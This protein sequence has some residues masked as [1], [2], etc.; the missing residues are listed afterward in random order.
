[1]KRLLILFFSILFINGF[2]QDTLKGYTLHK[3]TIKLKEVE[4][5]AF[6]PYQANFL[7]PISFKNLS[8]VDI[9]IKNYGQEPS[10]ILNTT[11]AIT[12]FS[13]AG[14]PWGYSYIRLRGIDQTR[15]NMTLNGVP[16]N[17][18]E[19]QGCYF[20][21]FPDFLQSLDMLQIQRG[22]GTTKNGVSS[23]G[24]SL[25]F[26]SYQPK[27]TS[28]SATIGGGSFGALKIG[29]QIDQK[30]K[31]GG[32]YIQMTDVASD[33]YKYHSS[34]HSQ[35]FF[36]NSYYDIGKNTF[37]IIGFAGRQENQLA[38]L[39][40]PIDSINKDRRINGASDKEH[41]Q[42]EQ[43]HIQFH[44]IYNIS[45]TSKLNYCVYY[46]HLNGF[47]TF[48]LYNFL[49]IPE[50]G[51]IYRYDLKSNFVGAYV[52]Y[53]QR[54]KRWN[55]YIGINGY[56]YNRNHIGSSDVDGY[57]YTNTGYRNE[58]SAYFKA[59][60]NVWKGLNLFADV[61]YRHTDFRYAG[62]VPLK[63]F[64]WDFI[65]YDLGIDYHLNDIVFYYSFGKTSREP[66]RN[67]IFYGN[68]NLQADSTG[69]PIYNDLKPETS[70]DHE[71]G[72]R[73]LDNDFS[74]DFN[75]FYMSFQNEITLN[76]QY[77]P[78]GLPLHDN[79]TKSYRKGFE[80]DI[81]YKWD[82]NKFNVIGVGVNGSYNDCVI[83]QVGTSSKPVLSPLWLANCDVYYKYKWFTVGLNYRY[84]DYSFVDFA[85]NNKINEFSTLNGK[86]GIVWQWVDFN[87]FVNNITNTNYFN[88]GQM[89]YDG[90]KP[91][92]FVGAPI[93]FFASLKMTLNY[94]KNNK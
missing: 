42:F 29:F 69:N 78:T 47:Y 89:N 58:A 87:I 48:D 49:E 82:L 25:N 13:D 59:R 64:S 65:N 1:M 41:D 24:G 8:K 43:Y 44:H 74:V 20:S 36:F 16:L 2:S 80:T 88:G 62:N 11:P 50:V 9:G 7:T 67:D 51:S 38:W 66:S 53:T 32:V 76:G 60:Y 18:P 71:L 54:V 45:N 23:F 35:S 34:N 46:N 92:Y 22:S 14:S 40:V 72:F 19:D 83:Q 10:Q 15:I 6:S 93:N 12:S 86:I 70:F 90:T 52:N 37:K 85:N 73:I 94:G 4:V 21:N 91:L 56:M 31:K 61:Q 63:F 39:G 33:G 17:E 81:R 26:D 55:F 68:D 3:D 77:G 28:V 27:K 84:Q 5:S 75:L 57:L 79:V 30:W